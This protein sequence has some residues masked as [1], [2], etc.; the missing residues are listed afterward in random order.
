MA[1][2][3]KTALQILINQNDIEYAEEMVQKCNINS[4]ISKKF[5]SKGKKNFYPSKN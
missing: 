4:C 1:C 5:Y 2:F 3:V